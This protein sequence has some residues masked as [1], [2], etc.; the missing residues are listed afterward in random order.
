MKELFAAGISFSTIFPEVQ[1]VCQE[2]NFRYSENFVG[3]VDKAF[4][5]FD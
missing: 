2:L 1:G 3:K 4:L 5:N